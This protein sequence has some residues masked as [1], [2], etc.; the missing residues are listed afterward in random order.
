[1]NRKVGLLLTRSVIYPSM[2]FDIAGGVRTALASMGAT[3]VEIK[4]ENI[5]IA[6][7]DKLTYAACERLLFDGCSIIAG[8]IN[9]LTAEKLQPLCDGAG[10]IFLHLDAGYHF[11]SSTKKQTGLFRVSLQ[12]TL[13]CRIIAAVAAADG[14]K[15]SAFAGSF[16]DAG[17]R[18]VFGFHH[19]LEDAGGAI[20]FNHITKLKRSEFTMEPLVQHL[21]ERQDVGVLAA[22]CGDMLQDFFAGAAAGSV[23]QG[24]QVYGSPFMADEVW[25]SQCVYAG[26]DIKVCVPW[27]GTLQHEGNRQYMQ[28]MADKKVKTNFF[29]VLGWEAGI[30]MA[31]ALK[32]DDAAAANTMLEGWSYDGPRGKVVIDADTHMANAPLY[33]GWVKKNSVTEHCVLEVTG[34][35][36]KVDVQRNKL[37]EEINN[38]TGPATSWH[39]A[40]GCLDN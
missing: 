4:T 40:Y 23:L 37:D 21:A 3:D 16:Y 26:V 5:G 39:N 32:A 1:M 8:Y 7:D 24:R 36:G 38:F 13:C 19:G 29:S 15:N 25:L 35:Y 14:Q 9:P 12:G 22:F 27:A 34:E 30:I 11:P 20:T 31:K 2:G 18:G 28:A 33:L 6:G 10:A 17:Y